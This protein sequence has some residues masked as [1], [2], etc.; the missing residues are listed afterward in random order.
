MAE[1]ALG[2]ACTALERLA[3]AERHLRAAIAVAVR[4]NL[5]VRAAEARGSLSYALTLTGRTAEALREVDR[6]T[7]ALDGLPA[8]RLR[9]LRSLVLA[10]AGRFD[11]AAAGY[12]DALD[13]L[14]CAGGDE[15]LEADIRTNRSMVRV[16]RRDWRGVEDDLRRAHEL[17][18]ASRH[19]GRTAMVQHNR[20]LAAAARGDLPA[21]LRCFDDAERRYRA[22]GRDLGLL[23]V[24]R[25]EALLSAHLVPDARRAAEHAVAEFERRRNA[26]DLVQARLLLARAALL[27]GDPATALAEAE[28]ARSSAIRQGR[29]A[30]AALAAYYALRSRWQG[31]RAGVATVRAG[32]RVI[33][34]LTDAGWAVAALDARLI[35][36]RIALERGQAATARRELAEAA[37]TRER[38]PAELRAGAW[39]AQALLRLS[40]G[41]RRGAASALRAGMRVLD[42]FRASLGATEL[43]THA[44][45]HAS[46]LAGLGLRL[47]VEDGR[48]GQVLAWAERWRASAL[49]LRPVRPPDDAGLAADLAELRQVTVRLS[50]VVG[51]GGTDP[52]PLLRRQAALED[53]VRRR[54]WLAGGGQTHQP[55]TLAALGAALGP[56]ALVEY[57]D[58][59]VSLHAVVVRA[60]RVRLHPLGPSGE[61]ERELDALRFGLRRLAAQVGSRQ[62]LAAAAELVGDRASR[63]DGR[64]LE[65]LRADLGD[66][67][68]VVVPTG[69]L[70]ATPW[71]AL[72]SC[73][74]RPVSVAPSATLWHRAATSTGSSGPP[75]L[76]AGPDLPH[77]AA[78]VGELARRYPQAQVLTGAHASAGAVAAALNGAGLAHLAAHGRFRSDNPLFSSLRLA[79]GPLTV[80]DLE[81]LDRP[82]RHVVLPA[83]D[84]GLSAVHP[85]DELMGMSTALLALGTGSLVAAV[86]AVPDQATNPL[87]LRYHQHLHA[88]TGPAAALAAAQLELRGDATSPEWVTAMAFVCFG[89][90]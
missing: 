75:L 4:A 34:A 15:L 79:D 10:E 24:E 21:A 12:A 62:S 57:V 51:A 25:A 68:L 78:E 80:Y 33:R 90:G 26:V 60:G 49:R 39:H 86:C 9:M 31:G 44:S 81:Q 16:Q 52:G 18:S 72:P 27:D 59:G 13:T 11:E 38:G 58:A 14:R 85:G 46:E 45:G 74:G 83:C 88:G 30:W 37:G 5:P 67:P 61:I 48:A 50:D 23:P 66:G 53:A 40:H 29:R 8:A 43:R 32:R 82:P 3:E 69:A 47:A 17:Y 73:T 89:A 84:S 1:R 71:A 76:V 36:A 54:A 28:R 87:M 19:T 7:P 20:G 42:R 6:A 55:A 22:A 77:A 70:H 64:L 56:A 41:D 65:P 35:V 2:M 63:L